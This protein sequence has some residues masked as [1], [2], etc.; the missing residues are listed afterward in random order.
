[1]NTFFH[2]LTLSA[3]NGNLIVSEN[4]NDGLMMTNMLASKYHNSPFAT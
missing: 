1:M 4:E 2:K 3:E